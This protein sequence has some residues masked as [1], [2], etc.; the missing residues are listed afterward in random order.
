MAI[1]GRVTPDGLQDCLTRFSPDDALPNIISSL[2]LSSSKRCFQRFPTQPNPLI[3]FEHLSLFK[4][5]HLSQSVAVYSSGSGKGSQPGPFFL[6]GT[7]RQSQVQPGAARCTRV[8]PFLSDI[9]INLFQ[10][11]IIFYIIITNTIMMIAMAGK[12]TM[13]SITIAGM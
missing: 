10:I 13:M 8:Q 4:Q 2:S 9:F 5:K 3:A 11:S 6:K 12:Q 7:P 1:L